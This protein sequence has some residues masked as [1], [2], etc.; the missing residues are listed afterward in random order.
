MQARKNLIDTE[1]ELKNTANC[2]ADFKRNNAI[3]VLRK[4][5]ILEKEEV[6]PFKFYKKLAFWKVQ[7]TDMESFELKLN[8]D[9]KNHT[10]ILEYGKLLQLPPIGRIRI[11]WAKNNNEDLREFF[12]NSIP[13]KLKY[14]TLNLSN[15]TFVNMDFYIQALSPGLGRVTQN[16]FF[17]CFNFNGNT[18]ELTLKACKNIHTVIFYKW[19]IEVED[20]LNLREKEYK[21]ST[22]SFNGSGLMPEN[23]WNSHPNEL[24]KILN[25]ISTCN[26][27]KSL[28]K[29]NLTNC[30]IEKSDAELMLIQ[31][32]LFHIRVI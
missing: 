29:L 22:L 14:L 4:Q 16:V 31:N 8:L 17:G 27:K 23:N 15:K 30:G 13:K 9:F 18:F 21:I 25:G 19:V 5:N 11:N 3:T 1:N 24:R 20:E 6:W 26:L 10:R 7:P 12:K 2:L 28:Q 32:N